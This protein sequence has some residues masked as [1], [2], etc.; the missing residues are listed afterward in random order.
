[1]TGHRLS[2]LAF[3]LLVLGAIAF[4]FAGAPASVDA[5]QCLPCS[6]GSPTTTPVVTVTDVDCM[7][8]EMKAIN[9]LYA[10]AGCSS[11]F[12]VEELITT[13]ACHQ[14]GYNQWRVGMK[15]RFQ[16]KECINE[17]GL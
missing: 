14:V 1:M 3:A 10:M 8:S 17:P 16:C 2:L 6:L 4:T 7:W 9:Q 15:L 12:C 13:E 11:G 5:G